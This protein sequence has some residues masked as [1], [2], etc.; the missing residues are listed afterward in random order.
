MKNIYFTVGP[1]QLYPTVIKHIASAIKKDI[2]SL[3]HRGKE[4]KEIYQH[5][6]NML[7]NILNIPQSSY[8]FFVSSGHEGMERV[9]M[10]TVYKHSF[11]LV[12]G[13]FSEKFYNQA[14]GLKKQPKKIE[15]LKGAGF[16]F[17]KITK[18]FQS[19]TMQYFRHATSIA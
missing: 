16:D 8:V 1:S 4:F 11:H 18:C 15:I 2:P 13:A 17:K 3:N 19:Y 9:L 10:N 7:R 6:E 14:L 5:T 12:S